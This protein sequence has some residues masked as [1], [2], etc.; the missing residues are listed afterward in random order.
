MCGGYVG[1]LSIKGNQKGIIRNLGG[2]EEILI[3]FK[4]T[5]EGNRRTLGGV[6]QTLGRTN[7]TFG[8]IEGTLGGLKG[9]LRDKHKGLWV[10][11][12]RLGEV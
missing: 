1:Q 4:G 8:E 12:M 5:V 9:T 7:E 11:L 3:E 6:R 2:S 10:A